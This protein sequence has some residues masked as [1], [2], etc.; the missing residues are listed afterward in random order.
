MFFFSALSSPTAKR[1]VASLGPFGSF[2]ALLG[3]ALAVAKPDFFALRM[4]DF[5]EDIRF[6]EVKVA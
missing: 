4:K 6:I 5:R 2:L 1:G 3:I